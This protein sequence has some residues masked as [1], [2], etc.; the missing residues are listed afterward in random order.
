MI[1][2]ALGSFELPDVARGISF[3][4]LRTIIQ[5]LKNV[6]HAIQTCRI[7]PRKCACVCVCVCV[8]VCGVCVCVWCALADIRLSQLAV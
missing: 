4:H 1:I 7:E 2:V 6:T 8:C 5:C 3:T